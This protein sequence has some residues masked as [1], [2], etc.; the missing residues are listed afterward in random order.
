MNDLDMLES[1]ALRLIQGME[2]LGVNWW[3]C[4]G[5]SFRK[6]RQEELINGSGSEDHEQEPESGSGAPPTL[7]AGDDGGDV[8]G[9]PL[10]GKSKAF[11]R[12][13]VAKKAAKAELRSRRPFSRSRRGRLAKRG[14]R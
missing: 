2:E 4:E 3:V 9:W 12:A 11:R 1:L 7:E 10:V 6:L 5:W 14:Y 8:V 13:V